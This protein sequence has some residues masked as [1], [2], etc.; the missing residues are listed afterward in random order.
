ADALGA[1]WMG[2]Q[3]GLAVIR[4]GVIS[5]VQ[6]PGGAR[7]DGVL[8]IASDPRTGVWLCHSG[9]RWLSRWDG[10]TLTGFDEPEVDRECT[11]LYHDSKG[12]T[13]I[14]YADGLVAVRE[15]GQFHFYSEKDGLSGSRI[16]AIHEDAEGIVWVATSRGLSRMKNGV[17]TTLTERHGLPAESLNALVEDYEGCLW[18]SFASGIVR[19]K[20]TEFDR[21]AADPSYRV[22]YR[23][24]D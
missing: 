11:T 20:K 7:L 21:A 5:A 14:G 15:A 9:E 3:N 10:R 13:W 24:L 17:F 4:N 6:L 23:L 19:L 12:R 18:L 16:S 22:A 1:V 2:T 8:A